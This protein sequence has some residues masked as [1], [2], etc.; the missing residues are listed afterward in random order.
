MVL[1][2][3][4]SREESEEIKTAVMFAV[5]TNPGK[6]IEEIYR[7][8]S[9]KIEEILG[10]GEGGNVV[11]LYSRNQLEKLIKAASELFTSRAAVRA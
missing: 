11:A 7:I 9:P 5:G 4:V 8:V 6:S 10:G 2:E 1:M 3:R